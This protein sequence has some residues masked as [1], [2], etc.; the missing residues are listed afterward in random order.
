MLNRQK[1]KEEANNVAG[2]IVKDESEASDL[3]IATTIECAMFSTPIAKWV[4][5]LGASKHF[6]GCQSDLMQLKRW[7]IPKS[8]RIAN[9][10]LVEAI[11]YSL[12]R[13]GRL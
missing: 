1:D 8:V 2:H 6:T 13:I 10:S 7:N 5:D 11:G 12:V 3:Y 9:G 4:L